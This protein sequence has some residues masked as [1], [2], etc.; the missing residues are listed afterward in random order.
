MLVLLFLSWTGVATLVSFFNTGNRIANAQRAAGLQT[1]CNPWIGLLL[2][3]CFGLQ[4]LY[5]QAELNKIVDSY[6]VPE[7]TGIALRA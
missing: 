4:V 3:F 5:Y 1:S 2:C 7:G 6:G